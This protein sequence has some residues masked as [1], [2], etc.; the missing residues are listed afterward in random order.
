MLDFL[1]STDKELK[2]YDGGHGNLILLFSRQIR[3]DILDWLD[4]Y[5]GPV[6]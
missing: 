4:R 3:S 6:N 5:L 1:G 2:T